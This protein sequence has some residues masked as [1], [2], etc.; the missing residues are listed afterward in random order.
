ME[1]D[2][3]ALVG[4]TPGSGESVEEDTGALVGVA[5]GAGEAA[6]EGDLRVKEVEREGRFEMRR[7]KERGIWR[8]ARLGNRFDQSLS[9]QMAGMHV[10]NS[11]FVVGHQSE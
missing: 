11:L 9:F 8:I 1:E 7:E 2:T 10:Q 6:E 3:G 4:V 5:L